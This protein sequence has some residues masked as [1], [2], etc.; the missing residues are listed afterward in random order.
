ME[1]S[2]QVK[3]LLSLFVG[4][5]DAYGLGSRS[6]VTVRE[7]LTDSLICD[8]LKGL[9]RIGA[10][11]IGKDNTVKTGC[12]DLDRDNKN[13]LQKIV[14]ALIENNFF[15]Y[16]E[17]SKSK[18]YH[19]WIFFDEPIKAATVRKVLSRILK[20]AGIDGIEVFPKQDEL[21][22]DNGLGNYVFL[23]E[24]GDSVKKERTVFVNFNFEPFPDQWEHLSKV[25]RTKTEN[26]LSMADG[27]QEEPKAQQ[28]KMDSIPEGSLDVPKYLAAHNIPF[29]E[30]K[31]PTRTIFTLPRCLWAENHT[32]KSAQGDS[33]I[34]QG[35]DGKLGYQC[36][37]NHCSNKTWADARKKISRDEPLTQFLKWYQ[38]PKAELRPRGEGKSLSQMLNTPEIE[39]KYL[40]KPLLSRGDKGF[41]VSSY[42]MGK[43]LFL[44][45]L[46]LCLSMATPFL[47]FEIPEPAKVLNIRFEVKDLRFRKRLQSQV[48]GLGSI[49]DLKIEPIFELVRGFNINDKK[50]FEWLLGMVDKHEAEVLMLDPLYKIANM[51]LKDTANAMPLIRRFD[52]VIERFPDL[53]IITAHHLRKQ[54]GD[55]RDSWDSTY[56]PMFFFADMDFEI[57]IKAKHRENPTFTFEHI[58]NDVPVE[59]FTFKRNPETL[60]Y[61]VSHPETDHLEEIFEHIEQNKPT[62]TGLKE[63]MISSLGLS[64]R[65]SL[66][67]IDRLITDNKIAYEGKKTRGHL[68]LIEGG[69]LL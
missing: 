49:D 64:T 10:F 62:K 66:G 33:A 13:E 2:D 21:N 57:R 8:H 39:E 61:Y 34:I 24:Q 15:P 59:S 32:T 53:L 31:E 50:D 47:G 9:K 29:K 1:P 18:G 43:T 55:E 42:K 36:F 6:P 69:K 3:T 23:P 12:I 58:S 19:V 27:I 17:R 20:K 60:L 41:I 65:Q 51:D 38:E 37:H 25:Y 4:R 11:L 35:N 52:S 63:W 28:I 44:A 26:I 40:V 22:P 30:K 54:T 16:L 68:T 46:T 67:T 14:A 56:G 45:Q 48:N 5:D 7:P